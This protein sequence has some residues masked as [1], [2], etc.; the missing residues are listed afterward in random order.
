M[1]TFPNMNKILGISNESLISEF[2][3]NNQ[4][5]CDE[6]VDFVT[7]YIQKAKTPPPT[8]K[9]YAFFK[10]RGVK[11]PVNTKQFCKLFAPILK[12]KSEAKSKPEEN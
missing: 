7:D 12:E 4:A 1:R 6:F 2:V 8:P 11:L 9:V 10:N 5:V 3:R